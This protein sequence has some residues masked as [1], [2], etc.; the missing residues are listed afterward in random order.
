MDVTS[1]PPQPL[2]PIAWACAACERD[3]VTP[4]PTVPTSHGLCGVH[5]ELTRLENR[6]GIWK[7]R[8]A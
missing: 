5:L 3:G 8:A 4:K 2:P 7:R 1:L 6:L